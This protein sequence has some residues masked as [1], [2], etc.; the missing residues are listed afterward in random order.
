MLRNVEKVLGIEA[1]SACQGINFSLPLSLG[2][3]TDAAFRAFR[4]VVPYIDKDRFLYP[5]ECDAIELIRSGALVR[6]VE[7]AIGELN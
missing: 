7:A 5:M 1:M 2:R 6:A 3:G 4:E